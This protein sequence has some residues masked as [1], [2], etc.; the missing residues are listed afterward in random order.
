MPKPEFR[1]ITTLDGTRIFKT[2]YRQYIE[3]GVEYLNNNIPVD[4]NGQVEIS[5]SID[6]T[7]QKLIT[8]PIMSGTVIG[9]PKE[10]SQL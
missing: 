2:F 5:R 9:T 1:F 3:S 6:G 8:F 4:T 10:A 7:W